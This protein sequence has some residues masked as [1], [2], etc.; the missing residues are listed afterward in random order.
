MA[1]ESFKKATKILS[2]K[3]QKAKV[4]ANLRKLE[5]YEKIPYLKNLSEQ[6]AQTS[7]KLTKMIFS[8]DDNVNQA[9]EQIKNENLK[10]QQEQREILVANGYP[11]DYLEIKYSCNKCKDTGYVKGLKCQ[12]LKELITEL[13]V[14]QFNQST[15]VTPKT[16]EMFSLNYYSEVA[17]DRNVSPRKHMGEIFEFCKAYAYQFTKNS[18]SVLM[19]GETGLGK[20]HLSLSIANVIMRNGY[21]A[22]YISALDLFRMLQ[23]EYYGKG[24]PDKN[25]MQ[26]VLDADLVIIDDLGAEFESQFNN[27]SLYNIINTRLNSNKPTII[28][29]N[30]TAN[31]IERRYLSRV[32]SRLMTLYKCLKFVGKDIRQIKLHNNEI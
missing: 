27:A 25:T 12:C 19:M 21:V 7:L 5:V 23:N 18:P 16:F 14:Y 24:D 20:T 15:N 9:V 4:E 28:N 17:S 29:T 1:T 8:G 3:Q 26:T 22:L 11:F 2:Q 10:I 30:L 6:L 32:A 13:N 31:E